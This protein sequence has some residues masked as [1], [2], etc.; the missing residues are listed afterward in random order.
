MVGQPSSTIIFLP[1]FIR[2]EKMQ[3]V[4]MTQIELDDKGVA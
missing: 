3:P 2:G 4:A 1:I